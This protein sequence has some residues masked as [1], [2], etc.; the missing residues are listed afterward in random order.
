MQSNRNAILIGIATI[1]LTSIVPSVVSAQFIGVSGRKDHVFDPVNRILYI[2]T[3]TTVQRWDAA[4]GTLLAPWTLGGELGG[5]DVT[6]DGATILV[7]DRTFNTATDRGLIQRINASD[8]AVTT[9]DFALD[10]G[11]P[12]FTE[13]GSWDVVAM[14]N[15]KAFFTTDFV[16]SAWVPFH[17]LDLATN[18]ITSRADTLSSGFGGEVRERTA[19]FRNGDHS[20]MLGLEGDISSGPFFSYSALSDTFLG[21][22]GTS[23]FL[24]D[25][26]GA[27]SRN[28]NWVAVETNAGLR[29]YDSSIGAVIQTLPGL[30]GGAI[31]HPNADYLFGLN[32]ATDQIVVYRTGTWNVVTSIPA[33]VGL[34]TTSRFSSGVVSFDPATNALFVSVTRGIQRIATNIPEPNSALLLFVA[35]AALC[36]HRRPHRS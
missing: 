21:D 17:Q 34:A 20:V 14:N 36:Q 7:A 3:A 18:A 1:V 5:I 33:G 10:G 31:F 23:D 8:G 30:D 35:I 11:E 29:I 9:L 12:S 13:T 25:A 6:P 24:S 19:V 32:S 15:G 22:G 2:T 4:T 28:G 27:V 26:V 16:G